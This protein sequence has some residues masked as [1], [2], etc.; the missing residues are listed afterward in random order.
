[1]DP[2]K[3]NLQRILEKTGKKTE[4]EYEVLEEKHAKGQVLIKNLTQGIYEV[5]VFHEGGDPII[6]IIADS[7]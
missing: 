3:Q 1:M 7:L 6:A 2:E 4:I 5:T